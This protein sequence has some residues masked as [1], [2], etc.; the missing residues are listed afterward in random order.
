[1]HAVLCTPGSTI[2]WESGTGYIEFRRWYIFTSGVAWVSIGI[3]NVVDGLF[4]SNFAY[5]H[6]RPNDIVVVF[7]NFAVYFN[8]PATSW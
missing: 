4:N 1:M 3:Q 8:N 7:V 5:E 6:L 2:F